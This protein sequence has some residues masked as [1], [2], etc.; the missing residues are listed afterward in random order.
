MCPPE[1]GTCPAKRDREQ[2]IMKRIFVD[3]EMNPVPR[4]HRAGLTELRHEVIEIGAVTLDE[5]NAEAASFKRF[6]RPQFS[7]TLAENI[8]RLTGITDE[9]VENAGGFGE[10]LAE[11]AEWCL[12]TGGADFEIYAWSDNDLKQLK[13]EVRRKQVELTE[14]C[15]TMFANWRDFQRVYSD[16][17]YL[18]Q[19]MS[20][21]KALEL[22]G[23]D[24]EGRAHDGLTDA[25]NTA[26]LYRQTQ[27]SK[28]FARLKALIDEMQRPHTTAL[29][30]LVDLS[31]WDLPSE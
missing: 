15:E 31:G 21:T 18:S 25:R 4:E 5:A 27:D 2:N 9:D 14:A 23:L 30:D 6:V 7:E 28:Q 3:L 24:F 10:V 11:F 29:G 8:V 22:S 26:D 20:L 13:R 1:A 12:E 17:F 19:V 16:M